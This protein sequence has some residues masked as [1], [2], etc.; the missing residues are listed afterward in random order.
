MT[1]FTST[2]E[3]TYNSSN[4]KV[5][6]VSS[7]GRIRAV[8]PGTARIT[9]TS[10]S[11]KA[12]VT[13]TVPGIADVNSSVTVNKGKNLTLKPTLYG[14]SDKVTYTSSNRKV[15]KVSSTGKIKGYKKGTAVITVTAGSYSVECKVT[16]K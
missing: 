12:T 11:K 15:A 2:E 1:P 3:I 8:A 10:G 16:V 13:V 9:V 6:A 4:S 7:S 5:T 14:I